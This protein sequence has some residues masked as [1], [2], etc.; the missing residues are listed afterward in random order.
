MGNTTHIPTIT[1]VWTPEN[2]AQQSLCFCSSYKIYINIT[3][4]FLCFILPVCTLAQLFLYVR[5]QFIVSIRK[6]HREVHEVNHSWVPGETNPKLLVGAI[7][8]GVVISYRLCCVGLHT[9]A[10]CSSV[11]QC[12]LACSAMWATQLL[13][14]TQH[15]SLILFPCCAL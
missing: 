10:I 5:W 4:I 2:T 14:Q 7:G 1:G 15:M 11:Y 6:R 9:F 13:K 3:H 8:L 12:L